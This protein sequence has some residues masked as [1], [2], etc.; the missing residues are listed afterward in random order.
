M[1]MKRPQTPPPSCLLSLPPTGGSNKHVR[2]TETEY[3]NTISRRLT[4]TKEGE[5]PDA[6]FGC[7]KGGPDTELRGSSEDKSIHST[8]HTVPSS[9]VFT[10]SI[11]PKSSVLKKNELFASLAIAIDAPA[12]ITGPLSLMKLPLSVR[13]EVYK[14]LLVVRGLICV[15]Q[16]HS[17]FHDEKKA[18]LYAERREL[19]P[20]ISYALAQL[21][22]G[23]YK[24]RFSRFST[25][26]INILCANKKVHAEAKAVLYGKNAFEIVKPTTEMCPPPDFSVR[27]F[28]S[29]CQCLVTKLNIRIRSFY[30]LHWLLNGGYNIL[31]NYYRGLDTLTLILEMD[32]T[33]R[34]FGREWSRMEG[35]KWTV[36]INRLRSV[37]ARELFRDPKSRNT[38]VVPIWMNLRVLFSGESYDEKAGRPDTATDITS[39]KVMEQTKRDELKHVLVETWELFKK[40]GK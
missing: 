24:I 14:I 32:T 18:F 23:G 2:F 22:V 11:S 39:D 29:G 25:T 26:N 35:E 7:F 3:T 33:N 36:Y 8:D 17:A 34:G 38:K 6:F 12:T 15:R 1:S 27:L 16:N 31:K 13:N 5:Y 20:G 30:D 10:T 21:A 4:K 19:L 40:G 28:P 9:P 37:L